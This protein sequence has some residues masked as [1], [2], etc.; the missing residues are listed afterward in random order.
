MWHGGAVRRLGNLGEKE[1]DVEWGRKEEGKERETCTS[2][3]L[4]GEVS[5]C[6][7]SCG[8]RR[9]EEAVSK[10]CSHTHT[11]THTHPRTPKVSFLSL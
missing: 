3:G 2:R 7:A 8:A 10:A 6:G 5:I 4:S 11:L 1:R 9:L